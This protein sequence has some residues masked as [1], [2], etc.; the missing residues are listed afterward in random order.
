MLPF[1]F[2][3]NISYMIVIL[4]CKDRCLLLARAA[5]ASQHKTQLFEGDNAYI[6]MDENLAFIILYAFAFVYHLG[7][8]DALWSSVGPHSLVQ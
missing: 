5:L 7:L 6:H 1:L 3:F 4:S 2:P 8:V